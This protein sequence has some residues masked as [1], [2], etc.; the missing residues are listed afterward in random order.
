MSHPCLELA[1]NH[2]HHLAHGPP[3][4]ARARGWDHSE[5]FDGRGR[6]KGEGGRGGPGVWTGAGFQGQAVPR[7][8]QPGHGS[9]DLADGQMGR[10]A[11]CEGRKEGRG[12]ERSEVRTVQMHWHD[13]VENDGRASQEWARVGSEGTTVQDLSASHYDSLGPDGPIHHYQKHYQSESTIWS[14]EAGI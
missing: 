10:W 11:R 3:A 1:C 8:G 12:Q 7:M 6:G 13:R 9:A 4:A 2:C 5:I 14:A